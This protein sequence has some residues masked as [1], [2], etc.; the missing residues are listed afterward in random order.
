MAIMCPT[1]PRIVWRVIPQEL[2]L[3]GDE[4]VYHL[5]H[6]LEIVRKIPQVLHGFEQYGHPMTMHIAVTGVHQSAFCWI[7]EEMFHQLFLHIRRFEVW[8]VALHSRLTSS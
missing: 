5:R 4:S 1:L 6:L 2:E 7:Q 3:M 8:I